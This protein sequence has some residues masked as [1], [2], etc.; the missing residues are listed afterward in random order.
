V[1]ELSSRRL[2]RE[3]DVRTRELRAATVAAQAANLAKTQFVTDVTHELRTPL[4][5]MLGYVE[6]I[7]E[8]VAEELAPA[9][10]EFFDSLELSAE[11][12]LDL[13]NN[14]LDL[15]K[16][17]SGRI[18]LATDEVDVA[19]VVEDV[20]N[21]LYPLAHEKDL[22]LKTEIEAEQ[23]YIETDE[24]WLSMILA[25]LVSNAVKYTDEGGVTL[26][27]EPAAL[28]DIPSIA[29]KVIDTGS[30]ISEAFMPRLFERFSREE[31]SAGDASAGTGLGLT[32]TREL[33]QLLGGEI[34]VAS[35]LGKGSTFTVVL[36]AY[37]TREAS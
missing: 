26:R 4:A 15:A 11:R 32:I 29:V 37:D 28:G 24:R 14:L 34:R 8:E 36:R 23:T 27:V 19:R 18:A 3:V 10:R 16:I 21:Q 2:R 9:Q 5:S 31:R 7:R 30:G 22:Y 12:L 6:L 1:A 17:E 20:R 33:V 25:N 35:R 13:V